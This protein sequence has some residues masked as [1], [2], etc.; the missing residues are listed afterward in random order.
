M[1]LGGRSKIEKPTMEGLKNCGYDTAMPC[2]GLAALSA[3]P[4]MQ[5]SIP[6]SSAGSGTSPFI[7]RSSWTPSG[8]KL[9]IT[10]FLCEQGLHLLLRL[11]CVSLGAEP[12]ATPLQV[13]R[14]TESFAMPPSPGERPWRRRCSISGCSPA[15][16]ELRFSISFSLTV[17]TRHSP[18]HP[19]PALLRNSHPALKPSPLHPFLSG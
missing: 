5:L 13:A 17:L 15:R 18:Q 6:R 4:E 10:L 19:G 1:R 14:R 7:H 2:D 11:C 8:Q 16:G 9:L 12:Q 3:P